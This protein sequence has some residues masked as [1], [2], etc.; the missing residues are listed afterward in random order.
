M[1]ARIIPVKT[2]FPWSYAE[3]AFIALGEMVDCKSW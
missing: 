1:Y 3:A 2:D